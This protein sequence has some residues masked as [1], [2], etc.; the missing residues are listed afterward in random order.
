MGTGQGWQ[1][2]D[3]GFDTLSLTKLYE[4]KI[5]QPGALPKRKRRYVAEEYGQA[6]S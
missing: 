3:S 6:V 2:S 1:G 4:S 5:G